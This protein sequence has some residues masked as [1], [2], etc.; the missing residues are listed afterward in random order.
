MVVQLSLEGPLV[1][2]VGA[3]VGPG[4]MCGAR[5]ALPINA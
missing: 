3:R 5:H 2:D 4:Q 1:A